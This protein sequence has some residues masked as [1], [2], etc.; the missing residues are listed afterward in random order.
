[1]SSRKSFKRVGTDPYRQA[2]LGCTIDTQKKLAGLDGVGTVPTW[3][4]RLL[5]NCRRAFS[6]PPESRESSRV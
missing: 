5:K 6:T 2:S 1:M 4:T 3:A